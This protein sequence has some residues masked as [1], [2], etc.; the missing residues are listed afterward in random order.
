MGDIFGLLVVLRVVRI[1]GAILTNRSAVD[2]SWCLTPGQVRKGDVSK[3]GRA[4]G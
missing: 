1:C 4:S 2:M 3:A